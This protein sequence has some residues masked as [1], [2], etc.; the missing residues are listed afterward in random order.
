MEAIRSSETS[1]T[2]L[3]TTRR[4]I[5]EDDTLRM[6]ICTAFIYTIIMTMSTSSDVL[7]M[8]LGKMN[9]RIDQISA[10]KMHITG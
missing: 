4:H 2:T 9:K 5:L 10:T 6:Y 7:C 3:R 1:G 8:D